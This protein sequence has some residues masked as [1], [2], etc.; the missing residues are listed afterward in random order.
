MEKSS[1]NL[2]ILPMNFYEKLVKYY[3]Q[4]F[5]LEEEILGFLQKRFA[6]REVVLDAACGTGTYTLALADSVQRTAGVDL[7]AG[8]IESAQLKARLQG[9][10]K[11]VSFFVG[12]MRDPVSAA[13]AGYGGLYCIGNS[14]VHLQNLNEVESTLKGFREA[15]SPRGVLVLQ[16]INFDR[17]LGGKV[18]DLPTLKSENV[19]FLRRYL[20]GEDAGHVEF[21][22]ELHVKTPEETYV[23][24]VPLL[25]L[26]SADLTRTA[27]NAGFKDIRLFGSY[28]GDPYSEADSFL[29][30]MEA[31]RA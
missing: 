8:M 23:Q 18:R 22:T 1:E 5:P 12:D 4:I 30:V 25:A 7:D 16:I 27:V 14:I 21:E 24:R 13:G 31:E 10:E 28:G 6:G 17:I 20:P 9:K 15:L 11:E 26:Q 2:Y 19:E 3:D 29:T